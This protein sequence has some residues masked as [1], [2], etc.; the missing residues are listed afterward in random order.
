[1]LGSIFINFSCRK[2]YI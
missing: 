2:T 1:V